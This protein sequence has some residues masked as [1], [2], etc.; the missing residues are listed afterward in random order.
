MLGGEEAERESSSWN[1]FCRREL[2]GWFWL[3]LAG[4]EYSGQP[5]PRERGR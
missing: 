4:Q 3:G 1:S 2:D 5:N